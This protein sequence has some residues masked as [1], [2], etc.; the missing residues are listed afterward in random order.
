[1]LPPL[2]T[3]N[4]ATLYYNILDGAIFK[5]GD[6]NVYHRHYIGCCSFKTVMR[7]VGYMQIPPINT[8]TTG[9]TQLKGAKR[10]LK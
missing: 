9:S 5:A 10:I 1:M 3:I 8:Q 7:S 4:A 2:N 6:N